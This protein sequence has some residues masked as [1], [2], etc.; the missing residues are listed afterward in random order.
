MVALLEGQWD[1][2]GY[3][4]GAR[5]DPVILLE[6]GLD[7]GSPAVRDQDNEHPSQDML[8][9]G[10]DLLSPPS[11]TFTLGARHPAGDVYTVLDE[12]ATAWGAWTQRGV[13]GAQCLLSYRR[14]GRTRCVYGRPRTWQ[15]ETPTVLQHEFRVLTAQFQ[16]SDVR[17]YSDTVSELVLGTVHTSTSSGVVFPTVLPAF[18]GSSPQA[19]AGQLTVTSPVPVPFTIGITGPTIG[20]ASGFRV[21]STGWEIELPA[22]IHPGQT[23]TVDTRTGVTAINGTA[24][25]TAIGR[26]SDL[27]ARLMPGPQEVQFTANDPSA[28][29]Q[30]YVRWR[31]ASTSW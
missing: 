4:F 31:E 25:T 3:K 16:L 28:S 26:A 13:P 9:F 1:L 23:L 5:T 17:S 12:F 15:I 20:V 24:V 27:G 30:A 29:V 11:W 19:R 14:G 6:S 18:F 8:M 7:T 22:T 10:R 21:A 2:D